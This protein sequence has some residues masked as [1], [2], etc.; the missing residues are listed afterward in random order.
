MSQIYASP[1]GFNGLRALACLSVAVYHLNQYRSITALSD[2][3]WDLYQFVAMWPVGISIFFILSAIIG[4][5]SF[6]RSIIS[7]APV[8]NTWDLIV[9]RFFRIAPAYYLALI[10]TFILV[11]IL[12]GYSDGMFLRFATGVTFL[13]WVHPFTFFPVEIN[14][15]LWY[16]SYDMMGA[17]LVLGTMSLLV[18][19]RKVFIPLVLT[20]IIGILIIL[21]LW[22]MSLPFPVLY[23]IVWVWFPS[24]NPFIFGIHFVM[25]IIVAGI[26]VWWEKNQNSDSHW[27]DVLFVLI[28]MGLLYFLWT[29]R[30][31]GD[32]DYSWLRSAYRFPFATIPIALLLLLTPS[33]RYIGKWLDN[34]ISSIIARLSYSIYLYH[35]V[36]IVLVTRFAFGG[37]HN[38]PVSEWLILVFVT[39]LWSFGISWL[40]YTYIEIPTSNWW[41]LRQDKNNTEVR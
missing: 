35:A 25:G 39:F 33:T 36:I 29:I 23:G 15:P 8:P 9:G 22:F 19:I 32:F 10:S 3:N 14:G 28:G 20:V 41:R 4:S 18:R 26:L 13:S 30:G 17:L 27:H 37:Q 2:W 38:L 16:I 7:D 5:L 31:A 12:N 34:H 24:Y 6:W 21:H 40:S 11:L 1:R